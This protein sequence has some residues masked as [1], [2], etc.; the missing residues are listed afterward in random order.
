MAQPT[1]EE[2]KAAL[3]VVMGVYD[4]MPAPIRK[5]IQTD[6]MGGQMLEI[7]AAFMTC[8]KAGMSDQAAADL[9]ENEIWRQSNARAVI[10][11]PEQPGA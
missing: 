7:Y 8:R 9:I 6:P 3:E 1:M 5:V 11:R 4:K 10:P 2:R